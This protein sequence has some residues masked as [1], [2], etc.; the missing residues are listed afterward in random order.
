MAVP[1]VRRQPVL[2]MDLSGDVIRLAVSHAS[3]T[4]TSGRCSLS[5]WHGDGGGGDSDGG[6]GDS[7]GDGGGDSGCGG[8]DS[9]CGG[10]DSGGGGGDDGGRMAREHVRS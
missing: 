6:G 3:A 9:G 10:D 8:V 7:G 1:Q 4:T 5:G 2:R